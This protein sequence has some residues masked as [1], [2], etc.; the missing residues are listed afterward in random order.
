MMFTKIWSRMECANSVGGVSVIKTN[1]SGLNLRAR[2]ALPFF[3]N[4]F[5]L[6]IY[7][8]S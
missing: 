1:G 6:V 7:D 4:T 3:L 2:H 5:H 8:P